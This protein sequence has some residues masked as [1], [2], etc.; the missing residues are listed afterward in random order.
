VPFDLVKA[1]SEP[2]IF[3]PKINRYLVASVDMD[4]GSSD[5]TALTFAKLGR[6]AI[7]GLIVSPQEGRWVG[8]RVPVRG[9]L[10]EPRRYV[11]P[12]YFLDYLMD[13][14]NNVFS[15][16]VSPNQQ[17]KIDAAARQADPADIL[18]SATFRALEQDVRM[19]GSSAFRGREEPE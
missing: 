1:S 3:P 5:T 4:I 16:T 10:L 17:Q 14:A 13:R 12:R 19:F 15:K 18:K 7:V 9:G 2:S 8:T 6:F 11:L